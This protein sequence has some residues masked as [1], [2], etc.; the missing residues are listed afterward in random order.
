MRKQIRLRCINP[1][2]IV[3][4]NNLKFLKQLNFIATRFFL[5]RLL[6][7]ERKI[8]STVTYHFFFFLRNYKLQKL[9]S[10]LANI[11]KTYTATGEK[12]I[13]MVTKIQQ[14]RDTVSLIENYRFF[15]YLN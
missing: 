10:N 7:S 15:K 12:Q 13:V 4:I 11:F 1:Q 6:K 2:K 9:F 5:T 8:M 3:P 14:C